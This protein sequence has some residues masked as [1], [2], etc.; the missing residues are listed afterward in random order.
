M[1]L[2]FRRRKNAFRHKL[3]TTLTVVG[4]VVAITAFGLLRTRS[5]MT[6][7]GVNASSSARLVTAARVTCP[8][9]AALP[10][11]PG[12]WQVDGVASVSWAN[13]F[14]ASTSRT[15]T[16]FPVR[17]RRADLS[18]HLF[19]FVLA[20]DEKKAFLTD[21]KG[22]IAGAS[23]PN[24]GLENRRSGAAARNDLP[25]HLTF[26][27]RGSITTA[28]EPTT[29]QSTFFPLVVPE[30]DGQ[31]PVSAPGDRDRRVHLALC[32]IRNRRRRC[33]AAIDAT[34]K[35]RSRH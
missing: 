9:T 35:T 20:A 19:E 31:A 12:R 7:A 6:G 29:D 21:R 27:L 26:T 28:R 34:F 32:A 18:R 10:M 33:V 15:A 14:G 13:W 23:L 30:R 2:P 25:R 22:A 24:D 17:D 1:Y 16:S 4:I 3:R 11:P 8:P 5:S